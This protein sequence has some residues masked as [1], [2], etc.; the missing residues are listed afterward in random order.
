MYKTPHM[1]NIITSFF[2]LFISQLLLSQVVINELD[3]DSPGIDD[4]E[5]IELK[6][7]SPNFALDGYVLVFFNGSTSGA[8][9]SYFTI[10]L[11]G[12]TTDQNG[13]LLIGSNTVTPFPQ[14]LISANLI[15]NGADAVGVY[16]GNDT[17]FPD[18]TLAT[19]TNLIHALAY[20]TSDSDDTVLMGLLDLTEQINEGSS[21]NTNSIQRKND[22]TYEVKLPKIKYPLQ[23]KLNSPTSL[24]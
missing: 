1:K 17:D 22:G 12:Y 2:F 3:C 6:S 7:V 16:L 13:L 4:K 20:D 18:G 15:Q 10:D 5:F 24:Q 9:S 8:D 19:T 14:L 11:D 21:G 23:L